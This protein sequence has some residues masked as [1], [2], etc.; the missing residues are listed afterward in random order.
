MKKTFGAIVL[1]ATCGC[2]TIRETTVPEVLHRALP[3][4]REVRLQ[5]AGFDAKQVTYVPAYGY[6][7]VTDFGGPVYVGHGRYRY[8]GP[9]TAMVSTTEFIPQVEATPA[10]RN[11]AAD[12]FER[13]GC[14]LQT[15][16]P[17]YRLDV[18]FEGP[19]AESGDG[20]A[21]IGWML[22]TI[23]TSEYAAQ[24]WTAKLRVHDVKTG[25][26]VLAKDLSQHY[27]IVTWGPIPIFSPAFDE[28][29][30][31]GRISAWCLTTL[32][33]TA[34]AETLNFLASQPVTPR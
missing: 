16:D 31:S 21:T 25:K 5:I 20:W 19:F 7:T 4:G 2:L 23:F 13:C 14:I 1:L 11:R 30:E 27:E 32:T 3:K 29:T 28:R 33:D 22:C 26:L 15:T 9:R 6:A 24:T 34:V 12:A 18:T 8:T 17:Q 10:Y